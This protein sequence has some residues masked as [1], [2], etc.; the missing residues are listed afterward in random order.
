MSSDDDGLLGRISG[1]V[2]DALGGSETPGDADPDIEYEPTPDQK[3]MHD[4]MV[5]L[6]ASQTADLDEEGEG[7]AEGGDGGPDE[8]DQ[9]DGAEAESDAEASTG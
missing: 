6:G 9:S 3:I 2:K 5:V 8:S 1:K 7:G 4:G